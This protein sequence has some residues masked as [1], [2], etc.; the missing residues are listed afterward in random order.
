MS[1]IVELS[2][3][4]VKELFAVLHLVRNALPEGERDD[5]E[6]ALVKL[7]WAIKDHPVDLEADAV[8]PGSS[9]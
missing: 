8:D 3:D 1:E 9:P 4:D 2:E 6:K 7:R 5:L